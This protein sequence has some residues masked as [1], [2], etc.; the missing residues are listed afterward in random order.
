MSK[1]YNA[2]EDN[3]LHIVKTHKNIDLGYE[4]LKIKKLTLI[5]FKNEIDGLKQGIYINR[6]WMRVGNSLPESKRTPAFNKKFYGYVELEEKVEEKISECEN[7]THY[8]FRAND[9][10]MRRY[11]NPALYTLYSEFKYH[12]GLDKR[13]RTDQS[14]ALRDSYLN[15]VDKLKFAA[16]SSLSPTNKIPDFQLKIK[17]C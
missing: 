12:C 8:G 6:K 7:N 9:P 13:G 16:V 11:F 4:D 10:F 2:T 5:Y 14:Q 1:I 3:N 17:K 15:I